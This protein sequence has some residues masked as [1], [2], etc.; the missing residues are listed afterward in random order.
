MPFILRHE[1]SLDS[2][3]IIQYLFYMLSLSWV[4]TTPSR[5][6][7][8]YTFG[9][10]STKL[11]RFSGRKTS[12]KREAGASN[13][14]SSITRREKYIIPQPT[15][16]GLW[17]NKRQGVGGK[18]R[19][20]SGGTGFLAISGIIFVFLVFN[21]WREYWMSHFSLLQLVLSGIE[22]E[23]FSCHQGDLWIGRL[24]DRNLGF[25]GEIREVWFLIWKIYFWGVF[26]FHVHYYWKLRI[27]FWIAELVFEIQN[28]IWVH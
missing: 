17:W 15:R 3:V 13:T 18:R 2:S 28:L 20:L 21:I 16:G 23:I 6:S 10:L 9:D 25:R 12:T 14:H 27:G 22:G 8:V 26:S 7:C 19:L 11:H 1:L 5:A 4:N 24:N